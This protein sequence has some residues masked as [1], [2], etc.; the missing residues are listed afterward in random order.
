[1]SNSLLKGHSNSKM[2]QTWKCCQSAPSQKAKNN[3]VRCQVVD[4]T[5]HH[6]FC[7][8][9]RILLQTDFLRK[10]VSSKD[11]QDFEEK[12]KS[13]TSDVY[14]EFNA[15]SYYSASAQSPF[16]TSLFC[17]T[18]SELD[19]SWPQRL[20]TQTVVWYKFT[21]GFW[22][23][24]RFNDE[25][26]PFLMGLPLLSQGLLRSAKIRFF[27]VHLKI[28]QRLWQSESN[29]LIVTKW[30]VIVT[31]HILSPS[32][33]PPKVQRLNFMISLVHVKVMLMTARRINRIS[34]FVVLP[35]H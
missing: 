20:V 12:G 7:L 22:T 29:Y 11:Q 32:S 24:E 8:Y 27:F 4:S 10:S 34:C 28:I 1:M 30:Q 17:L 23:L 25:W 15:S 5:S 16:W 9:R 19:V 3:K 35:I 26:F 21:R 13:F 33:Q 31:M 18:C 14:N 6:C 2:D